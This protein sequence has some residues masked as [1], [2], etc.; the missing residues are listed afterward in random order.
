MLRVR[1]EARWIERVLLAALPV[2][3]RIFVMDDHSDDYTCELVRRMDNKIT[4]INS[5]FVGIN[6]AR[7]KELLLS[8]VMGCVSDFHLEGNP[9][10]P[11]YALAIDGDEV[12][13]DGAAEKIHASLA[14][15]DVH[16]IHAF[17]LPIL[18]AWDRE[19]Q[20][21][22]DGVYRTF[23]RP[24][25]FRLMNK[26]FR[27]QRTPWGAKQPDG[28]SANFHCS[29]IPQELLHHAQTAPICPAR[30]LHMGYIDAEL[31]AKKYAW[32]NKIDPDNHAE[33]S[34]QHV[35]QGDP[36]GP[37]ANARLKHAGPLELV[38]LS[39]LK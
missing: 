25:L 10:S 8:R 12:L 11:F 35:W 5:P 2:C 16:G 36:G 23:A 18:Y 9:R 19:D 28:S 34:Y 27:F 17:K 6:E 24:S 20:I 26:A 14:M 3:E 39:S 4:L 31:R 30:V 15:A 22:V 32:Y 21:R 13:E 33:D 29:S 37:P 1:N 38:P 7:D